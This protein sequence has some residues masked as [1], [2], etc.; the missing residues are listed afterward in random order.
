MAGRHPGRTALVVIVAVVAIP[1]VALRWAAADAGDQAAG[2]LPPA[3]TVAPSV[4]KAATPLLSARRVPGIVTGKLATASL[5]QGVQAVGA[6]SPAPSCLLVTLDGASLYDLRAD[7]PLIPASNQKLITAAAALELLGADHRFVTTAVA[8][9]PAVSG[10]V[11][12]DLTLV[13]GGDP[14][15]A[16]QPYLDWLKASG[17]EV[18][19]P[20]T[21]FEALADRIVAAGVRTITGSVVGQEGRYDL[22]RRVPSWPA[23][24]R[25]SLEGGPLSSLLVNDG[26]TS[27]TPPQS[28]PDPAE[29]AAAVLTELLQARGVAVAGAPRSGAAAPGAAE[30]AR[31][32]SPPLTEVVREMLTTS[33]NNTAELL[34]KEIGLARG[35][36]GSTAAGAA[37]VTDLLAAWGVPSAGVVVVDGSGLDRGNRATCRALV[38]VLQRGGAPVVAGLAIAGETGTLADAF[39]S[40]PAKG[41]LRGK[42]GTLTGVKSLSG[43]M[44][45]EDHGI[46]FAYIVNAPNA[47]GRARPQWERL[48]AAFATYP[49]Q[50]PLGPFLPLPPITGAVAG[51]AAPTTASTTTGP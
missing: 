1:A 31:V 26:F 22:V 4:G 6:A 27:F 50:P 28:T 42:T 5:L 40:S 45:V 39:A 51:P 29:H 19:E 13:G 24:Y 23:A 44:P 41:R 21:S 16:T 9:E 30:V 32:E 15:L 11:R 35:G 12:G 38:A 17:K 33:D 37:A 2:G 49:D 36:V 48:G 7:A 43:V 8:S 34:L 47:D 3:T 18:A 25:S 46:A 10:L 20:H 14:L